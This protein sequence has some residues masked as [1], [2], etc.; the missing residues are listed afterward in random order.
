M[1]LIPDDPRQRTALVAAILAIGLFYLFWSYWYAPAKTEL[2]QLTSRLEQ[3]E[4]NNRRA[5]LAAARGGADLEARL[6][7]Y[8]RHVEQLEQLIPQSEEVPALLNAIAAEARRANLNRGDIAVMRPEPDQAGAFYTQHSYA[9]EV[10]GD[11]HDVGRFLTAVAS[12]SRIITPVDME[13]VPFQGDRSVLDPEL[14]A[15][16]RARFRIQTFIL[17]SGSAPPP[18]QGAPGQ[19]GGRT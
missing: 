12:L 10:I 19:Q 11:Y 2:D 3:L 16:V 8:E 18:P 17:P 5:Q 6:A 15:P 1:A 7:V 13:I 9:I 14:E 4:A